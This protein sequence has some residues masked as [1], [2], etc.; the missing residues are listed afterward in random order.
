MS[1]IYEARKAVLDTLRVETIMR[2][3]MTTL[4]GGQF[5]YEQLQR[6]GLGYKKQDVLSDFR[7]FQ[8]VDRSLTPETRE[9]AETWY[10]KVYEPFRKTN[11]YNTKQASD[12]LKRIREGTIS[13]VEQAKEAR[14]YI[15]QYEKAF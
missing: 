3:G 6:Q 1:F 12:A 10:D 11:G 14:G 15:E 7:R 8:A 2:Q 5:V 9:K 13:T 4:K